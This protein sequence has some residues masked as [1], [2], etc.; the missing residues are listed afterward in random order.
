MD[1]YANIPLIVGAIRN[2]KFRRRD[3]SRR[4]V[5]RRPS[6]RAILLLQ[7]DKLKFSKLQEHS[8]TPSS[9]TNVSKQNFLCE[10]IG[11][12]RNAQR[13]FQNIIGQNSVKSRRRNRCRAVLMIEDSGHNQ[14]KM[15]KASCSEEMDVNEEHMSAYDKIDNIKIDATRSRNDVGSEIV[16]ISN[17]RHH[18]DCLPSV[19]VAKNNI[20]HTSSLNRNVNRLKKKC[21]NLLGH[22]KSSRPGSSFFLTFYTKVNN[23]DKLHDC[24]PPTFSRTSDKNDIVCIHWPVE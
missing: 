24:I 7:H 20:T 22:K 6:C 23:L 13:G 10:I 14:F 17:D 21:E 5:N 8:D 9:H 11:A 4:T 1:W 18:Y 16:D 15:R 3:E 19:I 12:R 2:K